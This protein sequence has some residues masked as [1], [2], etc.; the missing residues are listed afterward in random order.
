MGEGWYGMV[1]VALDGID[2]V[3]KSTVAK[4]CWNDFK[5]PLVSADTLRFMN[6]DGT[7]PMEMREWGDFPTLAALLAVDADCILDRSFIS[8][9][10]YN[11]EP[12]AGSNICPPVYEAILPFANTMVNAIHFVYNDFHS[13]TTV[14]ARDPETTETKVLSDA[15]QFDGVYSDLGILPKHI[16]AEQALDEKVALIKGIFDL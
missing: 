8:T 13:T 9:L 15:R 4:A 6:P 16:F 3:G 1:I 12:K 2:K 10:A 14:E 11:R 5:I 7:L